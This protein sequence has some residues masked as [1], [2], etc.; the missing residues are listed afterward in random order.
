VV[1]D[2]DNDGKGDRIQDI[3]TGLPSVIYPWHGNNGIA[4]GPDGRLYFAVGSTANAAPETYRWAASVLS[5]NPDGSDLRVF[6]TGVRNP[7][8][9]A[10][11]AHGDLFATDNGPTGNDIFPPDRF[12]HIIEGEDYGF[13]KYDFLPDPASNSREPVAVFPVHSSADGVT[14]YESDQFPAAY[15]GN[16]FVALWN[17]GSIA[18]VE[19]ARTEDNSYLGRV[20][21][22]ATG[23]ARPIDVT[24]GPDGSL[25]MADFESSSI[26]RISHG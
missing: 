1:R 19:M 25:Y 12:D 22:F 23:F 8:D 17:S 16:A 4:F 18:R 3:V 13:P 24:V 15:R 6:A 14:F 11:N 5:V 10:F 21:L 7:Y 2:T 20:T 9:L 26:Y